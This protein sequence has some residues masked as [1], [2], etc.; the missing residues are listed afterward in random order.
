MMSIFLVIMVFSGGM[1][2]L[3]IFAFAF[4]F[5]TYFVNKILL[6]QYYK[7]SLTFTYEI[8]LACA[9]LFKYAIILKFIVGFFMF[10]N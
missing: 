7:T 10:L 2:V 9:R 8:P 1:P 6:I 5:F 4:F 3:Y